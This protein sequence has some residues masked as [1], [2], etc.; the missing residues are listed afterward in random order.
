MGQWLFSAPRQLV[1]AEKDHVRRILPR[2]FLL[3]RAP[4]N[5]N[6]T[7]TRKAAPPRVPASEA[8]RVPPGGEKVPHGVEER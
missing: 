1:L 5:R 3:S 4:E 8:L 6:Q 7:K 2:A